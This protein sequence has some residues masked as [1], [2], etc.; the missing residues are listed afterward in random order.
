MNL[1]ILDIFGM[2]K[3]PVNK[4]RS[5]SGPTENRPLCSGERHDFVSQTVRYSLDTSLNV[6]N[7]DGQLGFRPGFQP[8]RA[9]VQSHGRAT[10]A[11]D[12]CRACNQPEL[13]RLTY[14]CVIW[15]VFVHLCSGVSS[16]LFL[17]C[18]LIKYSSSFSSAEDSFPPLLLL[19]SCRHTNS[20]SVWKRTIYDTLDDQRQMRVCEWF[21]LHYFST[22]TA[23]QILFLSIFALFSI[24]NI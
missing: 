22:F 23:K 13:A 1:I 18:R 8:I 20:Q 19:S 15:P 17:C 10:S 6:T 9:R 5:E 14:F 21:G 2:Q 16:N 4:L 24:T 12:F 3:S 11:C 7:F